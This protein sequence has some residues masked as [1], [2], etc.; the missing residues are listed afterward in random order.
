MGQGTYIKVVDEDGNSNEVSA[1]HVAPEQSQPKG[2]I[3]LLQEIFGVNEYIRE[4]CEGYAEKGWEVIA[5]SLFDREIKKIE[6]NYDP[7]G[8]ER[9]RGLKEAV[10]SFSESDIAACCN[11]FQPG[12][13]LAV[14][15][16]CWG[17]SLAWR[18]ACRH[19]KF[20]VAVCYYGGEIP[21]LSSE[22]PRCPVQ[23]H[24]GA[25]DKT[26]PMPN[27]E[28]FMTLRPEVETYIYDAD[29]GFSCHHRSQHHKLS[30]ELAYKRVDEFLSQHLKNIN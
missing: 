2:G 10:D 14:I 7:Q 24:F 17:G 12:L 21:S 22:K 4:V 25:Q 5:P 30:A 28:N 16:Y 13:R 8:V 9:G 18:M 27:V 23:V 6:L 1:Y 29:H 3:V 15:G 20:E 11:Y 19:S 26:I